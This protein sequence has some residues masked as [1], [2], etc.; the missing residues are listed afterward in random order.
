MELRYDGAQVYFVEQHRVADPDYSLDCESYLEVPLALRI[1]TD[2]H[3]LARDFDLRLEV[4]FQGLGTASTDL[5][6]ED[7]QGYH[8]TWNESWKHTNRSLEMSTNSS[9]RHEG[10]ILE[11]A[12]DN[13][14]DGSDEVFDGSRYRSAGWTC[15]PAFPF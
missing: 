13:A 5:K 7:L 14:H 12:D 9:G 11:E 1:Q 10:A 4:D 6:N 2:D 8:Y 15:D 3:V